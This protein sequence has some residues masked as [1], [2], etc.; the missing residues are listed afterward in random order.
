MKP[1]NDA[2]V[3]IGSRYRWT[4]RA[5]GYAASITGTNADADGVAMTSARPG[6]AFRYVPRRTRTRSGMAGPAAA[7]KAS[8]SS[9]NGFR[10]RIGARRYSRWLSLVI[11]PWTSSSGWLLSIRDSQVLPARG[12]E[13][14]TATR[15]PAPFDVTPGPLPPLG[16]REPPHAHPR[17]RGAPGHVR[18]S[19][20][21]A[22]RA[23][24]R[25]DPPPDP[26]DQPGAPGRARGPALPPASEAGRRDT[27]RIPRP[28]PGVRGHRQRPPRPQEVRRPGLPSPRW[29]IPRAW[30]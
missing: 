11:W 23:A 2:T 14:T 4:Y 21:P 17:D 16:V 19:R 12:D 28:P 22:R 1:R 13:R 26:P 30:R 10:D 27:P 29:A 6:S 9:P 20:R 7:S 18:R 15:R 5:S 8:G 25:R 3:S 24:P